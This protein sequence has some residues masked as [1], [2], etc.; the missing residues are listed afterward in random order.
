[1]IT[2]LTLDGPVQTTHHIA[3]QLLYIAAADQFKEDPD[4]VIPL[5]DI[6]SADLTKVLEFCEHHV[7]RPYVYPRKPTGT[8]RMDKLY[9]DEFDVEF[10]TVT[11]ETL[12]RYMKAAL[13]LDV[14]ALLDLTVVKL[15]C[16]IRVLP[17][18]AIFDLLRITA[19]PDDRLKAKICERNSFTLN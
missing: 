3:T 11:V 7:L 13:Y 12:V 8:S 14:P 19:M 1:M 15:A 2:F 4:A 10:A 17:P 5:V 18:G 9:P 6:T 16:L